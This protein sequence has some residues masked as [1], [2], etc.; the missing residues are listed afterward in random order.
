MCVIKQT[1]LLS[2]WTFKENPLFTIL[3]LTGYVR[4][5]GKDTQNREM[6]LCK[7]SIQ[8]DY[9]KPLVPVSIFTHRAAATLAG[10]SRLLCHSPLHKVPSPIWE[11]L[12][13]NFFKK[14][15]RT[16]THL[17]QT[18]TTSNT[19]VLEEDTDV[20]S[21]RDKLFICGATCHLPEGQTGWTRCQKVK[22][23]E[24]ENQTE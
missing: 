18:L 16:W 9:P 10:L 11:C 24:R 21:R 17:G 14:R 6:V 1:K 20:E 8:T 12:Y 4:I 22:R 19:A 7:L 13:F 3:C 5:M 2:L 23:L 15:S